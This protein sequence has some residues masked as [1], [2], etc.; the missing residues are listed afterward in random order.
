MY[1][2]FLQYMDEEMRSKYGVSRHGVVQ[3]YLRT[4]EADVVKEVFGP[5]QMI[6][7]RTHGPS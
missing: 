6:A 4:V 1:W 3:W 2:G 7:K 5:P